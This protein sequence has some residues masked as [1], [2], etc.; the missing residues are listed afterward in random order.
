S[1][2]KYTPGIP[3]NQVISKT[4][5][6]LLQPEKNSTQAFE[7]K[8]PWKS[9]Y[10]IHN[11]FLL[12][13]KEDRILIVDQ[14]AAHERIL[15]ERARKAIY[16]NYTNTQQLLFPTTIQLN[17]FEFV[18]IKEIES[19]LHKLG[20]HFELMT[21]GELEIFSVPADIINIE[22]IKILREILAS[23]IE[24]SELQRSNIREHLIATYS[25]KAAIKT[26][27]ALTKEEMES[28]VDELLKC[29]TPFACP[30][31]RPTIIEITIDELDKTFCRNL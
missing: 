30:H 1:R 16:G 14:H 10:Q 7:E 17:P 29:E 8:K 2:L 11:K 24:T 6:N 26:G 15:F 5:E 31:G 21:N 25:C 18:A 12:I 27:Q 22:P 19:E 9:I 28:L 20:F 3:T 4:L 23:F 13:E